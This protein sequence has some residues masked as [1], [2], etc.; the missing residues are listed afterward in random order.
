VPLRIA[1]SSN[2]RL[3][4]DTNS[5]TSAASGKSE[6]SAPGSAALSISTAKLDGTNAPIIDIGTP[7]S[8]ESIQGF[9]RLV[10]VPSSANPDNVD[11]VVV[12]ST[13]LNAPKPTIPSLSPTSASSY[14][15]D[16]IAT[17][18]EDPFTLE[19]FDALMKHCAEK[20]KD[21]IL[22][23]VTTVDPNDESKFYYSYYMAHHVNKVLFRTQPE[24]GLLH[25][26]KAK[27][28]RN[29]NIHHNCTSSSINIKC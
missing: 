26:M 14:L 2:Q 19:A 12:H 13:T 29:P 15:V 25:R 16:V 7:L 5:V 28:V 18:N 6:P 20:G 11:T 23:R 9:I 3:G 1:N 8:A 24:E 4:P 17:E 27:N 10:G 22:A 21:F